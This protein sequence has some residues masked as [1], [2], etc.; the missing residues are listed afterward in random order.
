ME[1]RDILSIQL[2]DNALVNQKT[3]YYF[4]S[5][6][7]LV[8]PVATIYERDPKTAALL[9][10]IGVAFAVIN[11]LSIA[12]TAAF[13]RNWMAHLIRKDREYAFV[14]SSDGFWWWEKVSSNLILLTPPALGFFF[15]RGPFGNSQGDQARCPP[16][17]RCGHYAGKSGPSKRSVR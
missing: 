7:L 8:V 9:S 13:R 16:S 14:Y 6:A 1:S 17:T 11:F 10:A 2:A 3:T 4:A 5:N 12:R 15:G